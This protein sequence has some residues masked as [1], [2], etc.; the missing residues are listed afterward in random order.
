[1]TD[2]KFTYAEP[3]GPSFNLVASECI[4]MLAEIMLHTYANS[5]VGKLN[6]PVGAFAKQ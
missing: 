1:M 3:T 4:Q 6:K 5:V 2:L